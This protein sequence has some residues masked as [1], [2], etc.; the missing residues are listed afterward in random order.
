MDLICDICD[1]GPITIR[2]RGISLCPDCSGKLLEN[3]FGYLPKNVFPN[4]MGKIK[5][6]KAEP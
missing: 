4:L 5:A 6:K 1:S 2:I 3:I